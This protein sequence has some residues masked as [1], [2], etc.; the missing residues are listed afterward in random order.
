MTL[1]CKNDKNKTF[2]QKLSGTFRPKI[3]G[4]KKVK[5]LETTIKEHRRAVV[6]GDSNSIKDNTTR[7]SKI[8]QHANQFG[9]SIDFGQA[10]IFDEARNYHKRRF[11]EAW[12]S[13]RDRNARH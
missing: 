3:V 5:K 11:L 13:Q 10:T 8:A 9:H 7:E 2:I 4:L 1:T 12:H 6:V